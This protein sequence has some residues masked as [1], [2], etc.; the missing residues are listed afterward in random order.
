MNGA[1]RCR[2]P[3]IPGGEAGRGGGGEAAGLIKRDGAGGGGG[4]GRGD[5]RRGAGGGGGGGH[6]VSI[7]TSTRFQSDAVSRASL[8][9]RRCHRYGSQNAP[10]CRAPNRHRA[11]ICALRQI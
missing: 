7:L 3:A 9:A 2:A 11:N 4:G 10:M 6:S 5:G 8:A 1:G